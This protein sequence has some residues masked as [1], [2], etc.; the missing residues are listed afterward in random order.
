MEIQILR[1]LL[2]ETVDEMTSIYANYNEEPEK[3][4]REFKELI[5]KTKD[6]FVE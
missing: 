4:E 3:F 6:K 5:N 1:D 2:K